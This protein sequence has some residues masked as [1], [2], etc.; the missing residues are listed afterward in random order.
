MKRE[1]NFTPIKM[2]LLIAIMV[3]AVFCL[4][5]GVQKMENGQ[6]AESVKQLDSS[7][8][9]AVLTCYA[10]EGVYPPTVDYLKQNYGIQIDE[11]R[12]AV[13]YE[14]FGDNIMPEIT[15]VEKQE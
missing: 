10:T 5:K 14:V 1:I 8:R 12:F 9:K 15:I 11:D 7:I 6:Q 3:L 13:F 2:A 4:Y